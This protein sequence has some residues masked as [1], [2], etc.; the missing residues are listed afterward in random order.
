MPFQTVMIADIGSPVPRQPGGGGGGTPPSD[1]PPREEAPIFNAPRTVLGVVGLT[2]L[3]F[4]VSHYANE[5]VANLLF[6]HLVLLPIR[7]LSTQNLAYDWTATLLSPLGHALLHANWMHLIVNMGLLLGFG[8]ALTR[9]AGAA[10][11]L[12]IYFAS[13][14]AG[15]ALY[16]A[17]AADPQAPVIGASGGVSGVMGA[18][19]Q[20]GFAQMRGGP[21]APAPFH[22][23]GMAMTYSLS[24]FSINLVLAIFA[25]QIGI[26]WQAHLGG[27][28]AGFL[29][30]MLLDKRQILARRER[31]ASDQDE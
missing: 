26:A 21:L 9:R 10:G 31:A 16:V 23:R 12:A 8:T 28:A 11:F 7:F 4:L 20:M 5:E 27:F 22:R 30:N 6:A 24:F 25:A 13:V 17:L 3:I 19:C 2:A 18:I 14:L 15:G 1:P 29:L